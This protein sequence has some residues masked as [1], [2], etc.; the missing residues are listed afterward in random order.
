MDSGTS[1]AVLKAAGRK[2]FDAVVNPEVNHGCQPR[3]CPLRRE[4]ASN[5]HHEPT[6]K[7]KA[8]IF[9]EI[10]H[11]CGQRT[12]GKY[13]YWFQWLAEISGWNLTN[14]AWT[15]SARLLNGGASLYL[16][17]SDLEGESRTKPSE[18]T[19]HKA[20]IISRLLR[21]RERRSHGGYSLLNQRL[22][23]ISAPFFGKLLPNASLCIANSKASVLRR[24][25]DLGSRQSATDFS[26][27]PGCGF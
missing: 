22:T 17:D 20:N 25:G 21:N 24:S 23:G 12:H 27:K 9:S 6:H 15:A 3:I 8:I 13:H 5:S 4:R 18:A 1:N 26:L 10:G 11:F 14:F 7:C 2:E 19:A 16:S